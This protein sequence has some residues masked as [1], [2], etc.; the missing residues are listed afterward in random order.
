MKEEFID[1][2]IK[3]AELIRNRKYKNAIEFAQ[4]PC[5]ELSDENRDYLNKCVEIL[6][7]NHGL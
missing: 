2:T 5:I 3:F 4:N 7:R 1:F 6:K